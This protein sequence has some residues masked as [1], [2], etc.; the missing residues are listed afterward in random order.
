MGA[1]YAVFNNLTPQA[2]WFKLGV[3]TASAAEYRSLRLQLVQHS[4]SGDTAGV[5]KAATLTLSTTDL[6]GTVVYDAPSQLFGAHAELQTTTPLWGTIGQDFV[7]QRV[8]ETVYAIYFLNYPNHGTGFFSVQHAP[9]DAFSYSGTYHG[10]SLPPNGVHPMVLPLATPES[11]GAA[12]TDAATFTG[13]LACQNLTVSGTS[14]F[15]G[16]V[17]VL[18]TATTG[19]RIVTIDAPASNGT[20]FLYMKAKG[21]TGLTGNLFNNGTV[22]GLAID[23]LGRNMV[24]RVTNTSSVTLT[25][26][27]IYAN[28]A[29]NVGN[30]SANNKL[31]ALYDEGVSEN[32]ATAINFYGFGINPG[33]TRYQVPH[34][35]Y[36]HKFYFGTTLGF[37]VS[38][39]GGTPVSDARFKSELQ[40]IENALAKISQLQGR[41]FRMH[42]NEDR[43]MGFIAQEV[44]PIVP[45]VVLID[46]GED[47]WHS[48][49]YDKL[50]A[51]LCEGIKELLAKV[52]ALEARVTALDANPA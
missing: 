37:T 41:T 2:E 47:R 50:T 43:E 49:K 11:I 38:S 13:T 1:Q 46:D 45:E 20:S 34:T 7:V 48:L 39:T 33:F 31:L 19:N 35:S 25:P 5:F 28:G 3:Y 14:T 17:D 27:Q 29:L 51:L 22:F 32:P 52:T 18:G 21:A 4:T 26:L 9:G 24:F 30:Q 23:T 16:Q 36:T 44:L 10:T 40:P 8:S 12:P 6:F 15:N 42:G